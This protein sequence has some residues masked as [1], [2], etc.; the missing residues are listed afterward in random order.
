MHPRLCNTSLT[1]ALCFFIAASVPTA[2]AVTPA[3]QEDVV[4]PASIAFDV[5]PNGVDVTLPLGT[6]QQV[7]LQINNSDTLPRQPLVYEAWP[8]PPP[9]VAAVQ[10]ALPE[11]LRQVALP[12]QPERVDPELSLALAAA[13]TE[14]TEVLLFLADQPDLSPAYAITDWNAR[15]RFVYQTL[16]RHAEQSQGALRTWLDGQGI[17][18]RPL[19]VVNGLLV[20]ANQAE[21]QALSQRAE[22]ALLRANRIAQLGASLPPPGSRLAQFPVVNGCDID[23]TCWHVRQV[24]GYRTWADFGVSGQ[25]I[26]VA[27]IDSGVDFN[28]PALVQHYRGN[29]EGGSFEHAY[30]WFDPGRFPIPNDLSGASHGTHVM[31]TMVGRGNGTGNQP[32]VGIAPGA[33]WIAA[34]GCRGDS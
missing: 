21:V 7:Q 14:R 27:N 31:G 11:S 20:Q 34:R 6:S 30:N 17:A 24:S 3:A 28:H 13:P 15:G 10:E 12:E 1:L 26:T 5:T 33:R 23:G 25:G 8:P 2:R 32:A 29:R 9:G 16:A 22:V 18:Y 4:V 19:W